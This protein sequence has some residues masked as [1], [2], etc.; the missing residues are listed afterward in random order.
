MGEPLCGGYDVMS[1]IAW[2]NRYGLPVYT[3]LYFVTYEE[4]MILLQINTATNSKTCLE[5]PL[6]R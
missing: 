4:L 2:L 5:R 1:W 3:T 6:L